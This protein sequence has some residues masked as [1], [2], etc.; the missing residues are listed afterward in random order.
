MVSYSAVVFEQC[1]NTDKFLV[2]MHSNFP[3]PV[4]ANTLREGI[5]KGI[6]QIMLTDTTSGFFHYSF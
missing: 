2:T 6:L 1:E 5:I 4:L 3:S